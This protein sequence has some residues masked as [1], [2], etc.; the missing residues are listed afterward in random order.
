[1]KRFRVIIPTALIVLLIAL[2]RCGGISTIIEKEKVTLEQAIKVRDW[3]DRQRA[4]L[5]TQ[6]D[7]VRELGEPEEVEF[8]ENKVDPFLAK[9][10]ERLAT[11]KKAV[12]IW[13]G[14]EIGSPPP[15]GVGDIEWLVQK[16]MEGGV[17]LALLLT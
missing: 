13:Q 7:L 16:A 9:L 2:P 10:D 5:Q 14:L 8:L 4:F 3:L 12:A 17:M 15:A 11:F 1:M 6:V